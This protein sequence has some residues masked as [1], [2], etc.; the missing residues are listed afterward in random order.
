MGN[1]K[2]LKPGKN[3]LIRRVDYLLEYINKLNRNFEYVHKLITEYISFK[4]DE[5]LFK[6]HLKEVI[7]ANSQE[8]G[9][10][11]KSTST[12]NST[13]ER[14]SNA[15]EPADEKTKERI[16]GTGESGSIGV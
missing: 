16:E 9:Q 13:E 3:E 11:Q 5:D 14:E 10:F 12:D 7:N 8:S 15:K 2:K 1:A 4:G 6:E